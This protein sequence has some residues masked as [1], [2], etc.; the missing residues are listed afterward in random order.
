M[1]ARNTKRPYSVRSSAIHGRGVFATRTIRK[2]AVIIEYRGDRTTWEDA[3]ERAGRRHEDPEHTFIFELSDGKVIDGGSHG[4]AARWINH[5][6][7]PNCSTF[8]DDDRRVFIQAR[9]T[10]RAGEELTYDYRL[11]LD[12]RITHKLRAQYPCNCGARRCRG[13]LLWDK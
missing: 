10:I 3:S 11:T 4:N 2:G 13:T 5:S 6:C 7:S 9:R 12:E 1:P 8:E